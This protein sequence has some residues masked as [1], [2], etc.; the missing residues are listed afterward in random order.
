MAWQTMGDASTAFAPEP[1]LSVV[2]VL[3]H[4]DVRVDSAGYW[5]LET[6]NY[7]PG[8][9]SQEELWN[10]TPQASPPLLTVLS[11]VGMVPRVFSPL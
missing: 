1:Y 11:L 7:P 6:D 10:H 2:V 5:I 8:S 4:V 3:L 9:K